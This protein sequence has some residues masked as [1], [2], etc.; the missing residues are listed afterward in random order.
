MNIPEKIQF[1]DII[2]G[3]RGRTSYNGIEQLAESIRGNG[4]VQP[5]ILDTNF[6]LVAGGRRYEALKLL[7]V[8][9]LYHAT[10]SD[11]NRPG[12]V[13][14]GEDEQ[15]T[16]SNILSEI[17]ENLARQDLDWRDQLN[18]IVRA[19]K[20]A[21]SE[22]NIRGEE[23]LKWDFA[24]MID[25]D[26]QEL[27]AAVAIFDDVKAHPNRYENVWSIRGAYAELLKE[28][29]RYVSSIAAKKT[30]VKA[31]PSVDISVHEH[32]ASPQKTLEINL[33]QAFHNLDGL[34][35]LEA[36][37]GE[38]FDHIVTDPDYAIDVEV[39]NSNMDT[40]ASGVRQLSPEESLRDLE[41]FLA[42]AWGSL[43]PQG[44]CIF[45]YD[46]DHHEKLQILAKKV[47]FRIQRWPLIWKKTDMFSNAAPQH[48]FTKNVEYAMVCRRP[49]AT[50]VSTQ[51]SCVFECG[52]TNTVKILGHPFAK[53]TDL[54]RWIYNAVAIEGQVVFDPFVGCGSSAIAALRAGLRPIGCEINA[55]WYNLLLINLQSEY[56]KLV[57]GKVTFT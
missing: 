15:S 52:S 8:K 54:W 42:L 46:L 38:C 24:L 4:L 37:Q 12:F 35:F 6:N 7:G 41:T 18:L 31:A 45:F 2:L 32:E 55:D 11:P 16:L 57:G 50:L 26:Y 1:D 56:K 22:A 25:V 14:K 33:S 34:G 19:Y 23:L 47:G 36:N 3:E 20:L 5:I 9:E 48:N 28:N 10:T 51:T 27:K 21:Q 49:S 17:A 43:K 13:L 44:F 29:A 53:P 40:A 39:L 30:I